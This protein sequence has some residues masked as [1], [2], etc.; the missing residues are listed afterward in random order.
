VTHTGVHAAAIYR[1]SQTGCS[2]IAYFPLR[3]RTHSAKPVNTPNP[4]SGK[5]HSVE[6]PHK[7]MMIANAQHEPTIQNAIAKESGTLS[8][9][10]S[11]GANEGGFLSKP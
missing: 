11:L 5:I 7:Y 10:A 6:A 2:T 1:T 4:N 8:I 3:L 9:C